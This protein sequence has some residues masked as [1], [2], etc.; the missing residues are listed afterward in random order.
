M[1][2]DRIT[3]QKLEAVV[4]IPEK[5]LVEF[6]LSRYGDSVTQVGMVPSLTTIRSVEA[7]PTVLF[8][9]S[10]V[11]F[12]DATSLISEVEERELEALKQQAAEIIEESSG[13]SPKT[14]IEAERECPKAAQT[15]ER[16]RKSRTKT[17]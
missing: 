4:K 3:V 9:M 14:E 12:S 1:S 7:G 13:H 16:I 6:L 17:P 11:T 5:D 2:D 8:S 10:F 15:L